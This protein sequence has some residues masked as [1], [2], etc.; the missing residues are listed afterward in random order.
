MRSRVGLA[1]GLLVALSSC[2]APGPTRHPVPA[3]ALYEG[4][5]LNIR[6][7]NSEGWHLVQSNPSGMS[8]AK[9]GVAPNESFGAQVPLLRLEP[10]TT[11]AQFET[12]IKEGA[13]KDTDLGRFEVQEASYK[14]TNERSYE[15]VRTHSLVKDK[16]PQRSKE[17]LLLE[18]EGIY[19]RHPVRTDIGFAALYSYRG[20]ARY[21]KLYAEAQEFIKGVQVPAK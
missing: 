8:F 7:P 2:A 6:A 4:P 9:A 17:P 5:N 15:C 18:T 1:L 16:A 12:L 19:C 20:A 10:T 11:P 21:P 14:F 13:E 3:G